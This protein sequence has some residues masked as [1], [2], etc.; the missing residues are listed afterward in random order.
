MDDCV[1]REPLPPTRSSRTFLEDGR[2]LI[3]TQTRLGRTTKAERETENGTNVSVRL[4]DKHSS[5]R[6]CLERVTG[7]VFALPAA[8]LHCVAP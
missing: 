1:D 4:P 3:H 5:V 7:A 8:A 2:D 6:S